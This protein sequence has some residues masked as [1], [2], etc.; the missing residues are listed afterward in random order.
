MAREFSRPATGY[1]RIAHALAFDRG[2]SR[3]VVI[4]ALKSPMREWSINLFINWLI[5]WFIYSFI[6]LSIYLFVCL[7]IYLRIRNWTS[8]FDIR[9]LSPILFMP[10]SMRIT[11]LYCL[12]CLA[13]PTQTCRNIVLYYT[14]TYSKCTDLHKEY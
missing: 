8:G 13:K 3:N 9:S 14:E 10:C 6:Y 1:E 4:I 7:F 5:D 12:V 11:P 2:W